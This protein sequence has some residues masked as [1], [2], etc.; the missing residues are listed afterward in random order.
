MLRAHAARTIGA[1]TALGMSKN[2]TMSAV[3]IV[4]VRRTGDQ[5][6]VDCPVAG[7]AL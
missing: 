5:L 4:A 2:A 6:L 3:S 7:V 1:V